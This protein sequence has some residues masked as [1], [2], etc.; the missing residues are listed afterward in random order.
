MGIVK[1]VLGYLAE[2]GL[3]AYG[4][5]NAPILKGKNIEYVLYIRPIPK[6]AQSADTL[7][8]TVKNLVKRN[9]LGELQ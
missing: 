6:D 5:V 9:S 3:Y 4:I 7:A 1:K 2:S 8:E